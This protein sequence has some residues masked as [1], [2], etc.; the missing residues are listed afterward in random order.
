[1]ISLSKLGKFFLF[2]PLDLQ[3]EGKGKFGAGLFFRIGAVAVFEFRRKGLHDAEFGVFGEYVIQACAP[4][5]NVVHLAEPPRIR[6]AAD[7]SSVFSVEVFDPQVP[8]LRRSHAGLA[9]HEAADEHVGA[10]VARYG[11]VVFKARIF[12]LSQDVPLGA[13][14]EAGISAPEVVGVEAAVDAVTRR[15]EVVVVYTGS[16]AVAE[17]AFDFG[18]AR[19]DAVDVVIFAADVDAVYFAGNVA[20]LKFTIAAGYGKVIAAELGIDASTDE[21]LRGLGK[22]FSFHDAAEKATRLLKSGIGVTTNVMFGGP[23]ETEETVRA[24]IR[25]LRSLEP[26]HTLVFSGIRLFPNTPLYETAR[27]EGKIPE[28]WDGIREL[29]Y[30]ADGLDPEQLHETLVAGFRD[31][32]FCI[33][34]PDARNGE[35]RLL[36]KLG[37]ARLR[38]INAGGEDA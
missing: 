29:Y 1:M 17:E 32:R 14:V 35:L 4:G 12:I 8:G 7:V 11:R 6:S 18:I 30:F 21:T 9:V 37:Y 31:S 16:R 26:V 2:C 25:N 33:Y 23:G 15:V 34:P 10:V 3:L 20:H 36:H 19:L 13:E 5:G 38:R 27:R 24:G 22:T 28:G